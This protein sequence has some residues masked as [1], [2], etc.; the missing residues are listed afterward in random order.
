MARTEYGLQM[1]SLRDITKTDLKGALKVAADLGYKYIEFAG[2]FDHSAEEVKGWLDE[3]GLVC[4]S[5]HTGVSLLADDKL[6]DTL[7]YHQVI[8]CSRLIIPGADWSTE[9]SFNKNLALFAKAQKKAAEYG[10][11]VGYHNHSGEF[12]VTPYGK[13]IEDEILKNTDLKVQIDTFWSFNAGLDSVAY[14]ESIKNRVFAVHLKDG[15]PTE[16]ENRAWSTWT[17]GVQGKSLGDGKAPVAAV[18]EYALKNGLCM[19]VESETC[20]PTGIEEVGRCI[21]Y[22]RSLE[23]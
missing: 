22:L 14:L 12:F 10:I 7:R 4:C 16:A 23:A 3:Y 15:I 11:E 2:F 9:E 6:E 17:K 8:G 20:Q 1:Y 21:R 19:V 18:R 5:T 13:V